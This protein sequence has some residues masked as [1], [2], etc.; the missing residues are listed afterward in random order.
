VNE[1]QQISLRDIHLPAAVSWWPPAYGW[2]L[3]ALCLLLLAVIAWWLARR[4]SGRRATRLRESALRQLDAVETH[5][6]ATG[7]ARA[8]LAAI[9]VLL[10]RLAL[11][12]APRVQVAALT[13]HQWQ[14]WLT[15]H[16]GD[17]GEQSMAGALTE[18]PYQ[19]DPELDVLAL[20]ARC[21]A[22]IRSAHAGRPWT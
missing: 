2:W 6:R 11:S 4:R 9:S 7:D 3:L 21:R 20:S 8:A 19:P 22:C 13:G 18:L 12:V 5:Y 16:C 10:R 15:E 14:Q 17:T 1:L